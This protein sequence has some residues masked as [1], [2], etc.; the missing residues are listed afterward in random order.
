MLLHVDIP[1][2][3]N[4]LRE[5][6]EAPRLAEQEYRCSTRRNGYDKH[7]HAERIRRIEEI[8]EELVSLLRRN[9]TQ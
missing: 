2:R 6:I 8:K 7:V 1:A 4:L 3:I 5:E 9:A